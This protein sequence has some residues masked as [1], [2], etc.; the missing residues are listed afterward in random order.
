MLE[1]VQTKENSKVIEFR[2]PAT[3][4]YFY[5]LK[6]SRNP[7]IVLHPE[8]KSFMDKLSKFSGVTVASNYY[9]HSNL[10]RFPMRMNNGKSPITYGVAVDSVGCSEIVSFIKCLMDGSNMAHNYK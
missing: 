8:Q 9:H 10:S 7:K 6:T 3:E 5:L 1:C 2:F 4:N